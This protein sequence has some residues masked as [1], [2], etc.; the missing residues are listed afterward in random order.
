MK[1]IYK[2]VFRVKKVYKGRVLEKKIGEVSLADFSR[3]FNKP[4]EV[5]EWL[6]H[7]YAYKY[8]EHLA[9]GKFVLDIGCGTGYGIRELSNK[10]YDT[11]GIDIWRKGIRFCQQNCG[12]KSCF[13]VAS[14]TD[15]PFKDDLFDLVVSFQVIEHIQPDAVLNYLKEIKRV[16]KNGGIFIISTPNKRLRL[17]PFQKPWNPDHK[18]EYN[19]KELE[20]LLKKMFERVKILG[21]FATKDTYLVEYTRVKQNSLFVY[22][23]NPLF[24]IV[25]RI[26]PTYFI[27]TSKRVMA[28]IRKINE[29]PK[30]SGIINHKFSME[31]FRLSEKNIEACIDIYAVCAREF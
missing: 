9:E 11:V 20:K 16:L 10:A 5:V 30:S 28:K 19:A 2:K 27:I 26:L 15:L 1:D 21:L 24:S 18:K 25:E 13:L 4:E 3:T 14:G 22:I 8:A 7:L 17:L 12:A 23:L 29:K 31:D 6:K